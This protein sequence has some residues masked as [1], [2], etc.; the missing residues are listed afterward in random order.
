MRDLISDFAIHVG[1]AIALGPNGGDSREWHQQEAD[2]R[3]AEIRGLIAALALELREHLKAAT[4]PER[5]SVGNA[6][7]EVPLIAAAI[8]S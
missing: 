1:T 2:W 6:L 4:D 7:L 5:I 8:K 3:E